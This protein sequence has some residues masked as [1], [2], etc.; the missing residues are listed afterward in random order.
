MNAHVLRK[1]SL[2]KKLTLNSLPVLILLVFRCELIAAV[3]PSTR[4]PLA[5]VAYAVSD[6]GSRYKHTIIHN[7]FN[8]VNAPKFD[9][10]VRTSVADPNDESTQ[11][12][13]THR[14][15]SHAP[16][17]ADNGLWSRF[18]A[19]PPT[20]QPSYA[21]DVHANSRTNAAIDNHHRRQQQTHINYNNYYDTVNRSIQIDNTDKYSQKSTHNKV[22]N[23]HP[24]NQSTRFK[25]NTMDAVFASA[26][27]A[28]A[29]SGAIE[30]FVYAAMP[31]AGTHDVHEPNHRR[32]RSDPLLDRLLERHRS[33]LQRGRVSRQYMRSGNAIV[34]QQGQ[35]GRNRRESPSSSWPSRTHSRPHHRIHLN[36]HSQ[37]QSHAHAHAHSHQ[38]S[39]S[40]PLFSNS[41][42]NG[43]NNSSN[44]HTSTSPSTNNYDFGGRTMAAKR[45]R[46]CSAHD[47]TTLAFEAPIVFE[48]KVRSMSSDRRRNFSVTFEVKEIFKRG[49]GL[50]LPSMIRLKFTYKNASEC[51]IYREVFRSVGHLRHELEQGK[52]YILFVNQ[53]DL[54]NFTILGHPVK[55]SRKVL[56][57]VRSGADEKY[58]KQIVFLFRFRAVRCGPFILVLSCLRCV[59]SM[60]FGMRVHA[61]RSR[62]NVHHIAIRKL[63]TFRWEHWN[64]KTAAFVLIR[65]CCLKYTHG[66]RAHFASSA[67]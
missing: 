11:T 50:K 20:T 29:P 52:L 33:D 13:P 12:E 30:R 37:S 24:N 32:S 59:N 65:N 36:F 21:G 10:M 40:S 26:A 51:D 62:H 47:P 17:D 43:K 48:G 2:A 9:T 44:N 7:R 4:L 67:F 53:V 5:N 25:I 57:A 61:S 46:Y 3:A 63:T 27:A 60:I 16:Y 19:T 31:H 15:R 6:I 64:K 38:N 45:H 58:G 28:Y 54:F 55:R 66:S 8:N 35:K 41:S 18:G 39:H 23:N 56:Q 14:R 49:N 42:A 34:S 1:W 22:Y